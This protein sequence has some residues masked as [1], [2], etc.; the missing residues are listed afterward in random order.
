MIDFIK[1][2][3]TPKDWAALGLIVGVALVLTV[4]FVF[5]VHNKQREQLRQLHAENQQVLVD[6]NQARQIS[7]DIATL[8]QETE[9]VRLLVAEFERRLPARGEIPTLLDHFEALAKE[10]GINVQLDTSPRSRDARKE[11]IPYKIRARGT[12][13]QI[14]HFIN[15]LER[16][17]RYLKISDLNLGPEI[18]NICEASFTLSTFRF[19][20]PAEANVT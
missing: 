2:T 14:A 1:G 12:Y 9:K 20:D 17:E 8:E 11:T 6:L 13:H 4:G 15:R 18:G 16:F 3:I 7:A 10:V 5:V 19:I